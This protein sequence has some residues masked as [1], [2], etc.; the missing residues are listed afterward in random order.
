MG[1]ICRWHCLSHFLGADVVGVILHQFEHCRRS[2]GVVSGEEPSPPPLHGEIQHQNLIN[3]ACIMPSEMF[4][5]LRA[6]Y[7]SGCAK[8]AR[9]KRLQRQCRFLAY[10]D[11]G[12]QT[13][14]GALLRLAT[15]RLGF[16][17][18]RPSAPVQLG[19]RALVAC[20]LAS[21]VLR[22]GIALS[23]VSAAKPSILEAVRDKETHPGFREA[24]MSMLTCKCLCFSSHLTLCLP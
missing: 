21:S 4:N 17:I 22:S 23:I 9:G 2:Q 7:V 16:H 8:L 10:R 5:V 3:I 24:P 11:I 19:S 13:C 14:G 12:L 1:L 6:L 20:V 15:L 18:K